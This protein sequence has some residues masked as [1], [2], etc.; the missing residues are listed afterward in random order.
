M[1]ELFKFIRN[2]K[3]GKSY[4]VARSNLKFRSRGSSTTDTNDVTDAKTDKEIAEEINYLQTTLRYNNL[5]VYKENIKQ[6]KHRR[7][8]VYTLPAILVLT[9]IL[10]FIG[11]DNYVYSKNFDTYKK[12][13]THF[14]DG[15][16]E[17]KDDGI[18]YCF[19]DVSRTF[20]D[21]D[22]K[23]LTNRGSFLD[24]YILDDGEGVYAPY[25]FSG[26]ELLLNSKYINEGVFVVD[27]I[28]AKAGE[29]ISTIYSDMFDRAL[30]LLVDSKKVDKEY[31]SLL[32]N[33]DTDKKVNFVAKLVEY[34]Y[35]GKQEVNVFT[36][37]I[38]FRVVSSIVTALYLFIFGIPALRRPVIECEGLEVDG[39]KLK[40]EDHDH[41]H[42]F[43]E[44]PLEYKSA[45][46]AAETNRIMEL[47]R[48]A[49][50]YLTPDSKEMLFTNFEK[51]LILR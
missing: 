34:E 29:D 33:I 16:M 28:S 5:K 24:M 2:N 37:A 18:T 19:G 7:F 45:F 30:E 26:S 9:T 41:L 50:E 15:K 48:I 14:N 3:N 1:F 38:Y 43:T 49:D 8:A 35:I 40:N 22:K 20:E 23:S 27:G 10:S 32:E 46:I 47:A 4:A 13:E 39:P 6:V 36:P 25:S 51:K 17:T 21:S 12:I 44:L 11:P 42:R 31:Q